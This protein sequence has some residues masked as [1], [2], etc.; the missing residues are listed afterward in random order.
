MKKFLKIFGIF[1]VISFAITLFACDNETTKKS[2]KT[3]RGTT[4]T[5]ATTARVSTRGASETFT[6]T[7][8][9]DTKADTSSLTN[10]VKIINKS[11]NNQELHNG[12]KIYDDD[13]I[14]IT[15]F[16]CAS[17]V[18][19]R[20]VKMTNPSYDILPWFG[21]DKLTGSDA[22]TG[23][24]PIEFVVNAGIKVEV[25]VD[26]G[27][28]PAEM[29]KIYMNNIAQNA[30]LRVY[31]VEDLLAER[32]LEDDD[33]VEKG[34]TIYCD[35]ENKSTTET[36]LVTAISDN[37]V[38]AS[39]K[40]AP[41]AKTSDFYFGAGDINNVYVEAYSKNTITFTSPLLTVGKYVED[42]DDVRVTS[43][44][45]LD[46]YTM[47]KVTINNYTENNKVFKITSGTD[48]VYS[49]IINADT[50]DSTNYMILTSDVVISI[51]DIEGPTVT[52]PGLS[53]DNG[54]WVSVGYIYGDGDSMSVASGEKIPTGFKFEVVV[55]ILAEDQTTKF[56]VTIKIGTETV[57]TETA[58]FNESGY[59]IK[60]DNLIATDDILVTI[61]LHS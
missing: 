14:E 34:I 5:T 35:V 52:H 2:T 1:L 49:T 37:S 31:Y 60:G 26:D 33:Y 61:A 56:D 47:Y 27:T 53:I 20:V 22:T 15:L 9:V 58:S 50:N 32:D 46:K 44:S 21:F 25:V 6:L 19:M 23:Q 43:G 55:Y 40:L 24:E 17:D 29:G 3:T 42:S 30:T 12:D 59:I 38:D 28:D 16:N 54:Y 36:I 7:V 51:S 57:K 39:V 4:R 41:G 10:T 45:E 13:E 11:N 48:T 18:K 8:A